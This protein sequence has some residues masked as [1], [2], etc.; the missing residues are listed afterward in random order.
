M[1]IGDVLARKAGVNRILAYECPKGVLECV[2]DKVVF[3]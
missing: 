3:D 1:N 2:K